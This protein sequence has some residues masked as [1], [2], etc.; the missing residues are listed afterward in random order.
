MKIQFSDNSGEFLLIGETVEEIALL[1][2]LA[3]TPTS[4]GDFCLSDDLSNGP[5][6]RVLNAILEIQPEE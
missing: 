2:K 5:E 6:H 3:A 4:G 1:G